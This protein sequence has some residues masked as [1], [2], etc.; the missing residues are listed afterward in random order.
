MRKIT[1]TSLLLLL[2]ALGCTKEED[3]V[4]ATVGT[5]KIRV[6]DFLMVYRPNVYESEEAEM[7]TKHRALENMIDEKLLV[8]EARNRGYDQDTSLKEGIE[9]ATQSAMES[10]LYKK[11]VLDK[12]K[13]TRAEVKKYYE[14]EKQLLE[15]RL[16]H[17]DKEEEGKMVA[18][19]FATGVPFDTLVVLFSTDRSAASG[20]NIGK[21]ALARFYGTDVFDE[22]SNLGEAQITKPVENNRGGYDIFYLISQSVDEEVPPLEE[23]EEQITNWI[24][25]IKGAE[26][27]ETTLDQLFEESKVEYNDEGLGLLTKPRNQLT[28]QDL[29]VWT[30]KVAGEITDSVGSMLMLYPSDTTGIRPE[31]LENAA[32]YQ[33]QPKVLEKAALKRNMDR[34]R[35]V[36]E[37]V[38]SYINAM[39][40]QRIY[41]EEISNKVEITPEQVE[42]YYHDN[43]DE[44]FIPERRN[45]AIIRTN[46]YSVIQQAYSL[47]ASGKPFEEVA[48]EYSDHSSNTRGGL[49]GAKREDDAE[50]KPFVEQAFKISKGQYS[51]P[52]EV[53]NGFGIV[54]VLDI[55][56]AYTKEFEKEMRNI[57]RILRR[58]METVRKEEFLAELR[59]RIPIEINESLLAKIAKPEEEKPDSTETK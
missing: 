38:E 19:K 31:H 54:K 55:Q 14:A 30:I 2:T 23:R 37:N 12:S 3:K 26:L 48:R 17:V 10:A 40:R 51:R 57:E 27:A 45:L 34:D 58:E 1:F 5:E 43:P 6:K 25:R 24:E 50:Y 52:F 36:K 28:S 53:A 29:S 8:A 16:I 56:K 59:E 4:V 32:R 33:I 22:L 11:L 42:T 44:F 21:V 13:P 41:A 18:E 47:L 35:T 39:I 9:R 46:S 7:E 49:I 15:L 20:G